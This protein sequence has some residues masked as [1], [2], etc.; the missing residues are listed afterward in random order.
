MKI[1]LVDD[2]AGLL[3]VQ[4]TFL[5]KAG[6]EVITATNGQE[7]LDLAA[8]QTF[9]LM[10]TDIVMPEKEGI[11]IIRE[12]RQKF[13]EMKIIA[14]SGGGRVQAGDY[15]FIAKKLGADQTLSK[16]FTAAELLAAIK[17]VMPQIGA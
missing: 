8:I 10:I 2:N 12:L 5:R 13:P 6:Y 17:S 15:L 14:M 4:S 1:L 16:P 3:K 7:A 9:D 11:E